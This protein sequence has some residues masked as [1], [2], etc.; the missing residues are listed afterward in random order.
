MCSAEGQ[1]S[2]PAAVL[3]HLPLLVYRE[4]LRIRLPPLVHMSNNKF[5]DEAGSFS[6][7]NGCVDQYLSAV[8]LYAVSTES[9]HI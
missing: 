9:L 1:D 7:W 6:S 3:Q 2:F 8:R 5:G 4:L